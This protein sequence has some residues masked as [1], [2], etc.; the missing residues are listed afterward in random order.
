MVHAQFIEKKKKKLWNAG[1]EYMEWWQYTVISSSE[2]R[3]ETAHNH[4]DSQVRHFQ[5]SIQWTLSLPSTKWSS[6][7]ADTKW[8]KNRLIFRGR[9]AVHH[10]A[11][12]PV[13]R[14][15]QNKQKTTS[16]KEQ[17]KRQR[18]KWQIYNGTTGILRNKVNG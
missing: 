12:V 14:Q 3:Y 2:L 11:A 1:L 8:K 15:D 10:K 13:K 16:N 18:Q 9:F 4:I 7:A 5:K 6:A 17:P